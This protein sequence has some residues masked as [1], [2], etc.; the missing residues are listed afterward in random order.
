MQIESL[1][2]RHYRN[3]KQACISQLGQYNVFIGKN[4]AGKSTALHALFVAISA[5]TPEFVKRLKISSPIEDEF[6]NREID[7]TI[8]FGLEI[9]LTPQETEGLIDTFQREQG[10]EISPTIRSALDGERFSV[11]V[12]YFETGGYFVSY[13]RDVSLG[14]VRS[15]GSDLETSGE[16][17][18]ELSLDTA[19]RIFANRVEF[20]DA[21]ALAK[22]AT[23]AFEHRSDAINN[24]QQFFSYL[25]ASFGR[26]AEDKIREIWGQTGNI[27]SFGNETTKVRD[28]CSAKMRS[29]N[30]QRDQLLVSPGFEL[31]SSVVQRLLGAFAKL[32]VK[33]FGERKQVISQ[34][35]AEYLLKLKNSRQNKKRWQ[36]VRDVAKALLDVDLD[37]FGNSE[38][39]TAEIELG[40]FLPDATGAGIREALRLILDLEREKPNIALIEEPEV[41]LHPALARAVSNYLR[42]KSTEIQ[43]L[44]TSHS[45]EFVD[46]ATFQN[47]YLVS[48][49]A[50]KKTTIES[51][52]TSTGLQTL[53][54]ELG[55]RP[56]A[57]F[58]H[59]C[60]VFVEGPS[61]EE[62][63]REFARKMALDLARA[64]VGFVRLG[65]ITNLNS[66]AAEE[67]LSLLSRRQIGLWFIVDRDERD[68]DEIQ[69]MKIRLGDGA[70]LRVLERRELENYLL[71]PHAIRKF[72]EFKKRTS[73][74]KALPTEEEIATLISRVSLNLRNEAVTLRLKKR[75]LIPV[76]PNRNQELQSP[77]TDQI[78][79]AIIE[80]NH[81][82]TRVVEERNSIE[83]ELDHGWQDHS[84]DL[85]PGS[86]ILNKV[87]ASY[88]VNFNKGN[89][90][91]LR[92]AQFMTKDEIPK[93]IHETLTQIANKTQ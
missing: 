20:A 5:V 75:L 14:E 22:A 3:I 68:T 65:G 71:V 41:H 79:A 74:D 59:D 19:R 43:V 7:S 77:V 11:I 93:W 37:A 9:R 64:N 23:Y 55:L 57:V 86:L 54:A 49:K 81:R 13:V 17:L 61:D 39:K 70:K 45:T 82:L 83:K 66:Y 47:V 15:N 29:V 21:E 28:S 90:D 84:P 18:F 38:E 50:D 27:N 48:R 34:A 67:T 36:A 78:A 35:D 2:I 16:K 33:V 72:L 6:T 52:D 88:H 1:H 87:C 63:L 26:S 80:L 73:G 25:R 32:Q 60:L 8:K 12:V 4:N 89:G 40:E 51:L 42:E 76:Y 31:Y 91:S 24:Q 30:Y 56:S 46:A 58:M 85:A 92:I 69:K 62:V 44:L 10:Q 53:P